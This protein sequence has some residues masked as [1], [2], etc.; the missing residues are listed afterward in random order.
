MTPGP[1][2][3]CF[4]IS[5]DAF[6]SKI[7]G[8]DSSVYPTNSDEISLGLDKL[9]YYT[10]TY[11]KGGQHND[12]FSLVAR[13]DHLG[14]DDLLRLL[15]ALGYIPQVFDVE[16]P[17]YVNGV[18][19]GYVP[20]EIEGQPKWIKYPQH[21]T[22]NGESVYMSFNDT[23][24]TVCANSGYEVELADVQRAKRLESKMEREFFN[25]RVEVKLRRNLTR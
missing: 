17:R 18:Y 10:L 8:F 9:Q 13:F 22:V 16:Q 23:F 15:V 2:G 21:C 25:P 5:K 1:G 11:P 3:N 20:I 24:V 7:F 14:N 6:M 19:V 4:N 12:G